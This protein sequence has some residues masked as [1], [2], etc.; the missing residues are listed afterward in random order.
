[1]ETLYLILFCVSLLLNV[2]LI[3][4]LRNNKISSHKLKQQ[5]NDMQGQS[6][7]DFYG[8]GKLSEL[9]TLSAGITHEIS[10]PLTVIQG[11]LTRLMRTDFSA[12]KKEDLQKGLEQIY[13]QS[14]R[15]STIIQSV[16]Q[17]IYRDEK[18]VEDV[19]SLKE[20]IDN[21]LVFYGQRLKVHDIE[22]R[23]HDLDN[24]YV[25]GHRGQY[26]QA[27]LNLISN[28]FDAIDNQAE[29]WIEISATKS[30][31][32]VQILFKDSGLGIPEEIRTKMLDPFYST[33]KDKGTGL[34][35]TL[36]KEIALRH[37]GDF[38]YIDSPNTTFLLELPKASSIQ[39]HQ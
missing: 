39:Y 9:G 16:R 31:D 15:I 11:R 22:L 25:S 38:K 23:L 36:V 17:Y 14:E 7:E 3:F 33:K 12:L 8:K 27:I 20:I 6:Q 26:E 2:C 18:S 10:S 28:S 1:M 21:V 13:K 34:G 35:L 4:S 24:I 37:G 29:K 19:I 30:H 5:L 32:G